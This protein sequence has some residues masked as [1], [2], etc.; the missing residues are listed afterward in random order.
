MSECPQTS[1]LLLLARMEGRAQRMLEAVRIVA[2]PENRL[3]LH[4][5]T[6]CDA[7]RVQWER[8]ATNR[9]L[10]LPTIAMVGERNSG[11]SYL[12]SR[13]VLHPDA[14]KW[15]APGLSE[16]TKTERLL[17]V[18]PES[19]PS[20]VDPW[21]S[22]WPLDREAMVDLG[23]PYMLLD[24]PGSGDRS[25]QLQA[26]AQAALSSA[27]IKVL[28]VDSARRSAEAYRDAMKPGDGSVILPAIHLSAGET[29][30]WAQRSQEEAEASAAEYRQWTATL[31]SYW[32]RATVLEPVILPEIDAMPD[33]EAAGELVRERLA[34]ALRE[35][36]LAH[37]DPGAL[38]AAELAAAWERFGRVAG[39][40]L[41]AILTPALRKRHAGLQEARRTLPTAV[42][43]HLF[44]DGAK[45]R[46]LVRHRLR[47]SLVESI[48]NGA[49]PFRTVAKLLCLT[50]GA[51]D[52]LVLG[53]GGSLPSLALAGAT[54]WR[55]VREKETA[56]ATL[57]A[58]LKGQIES[59]VQERLRGP[60]E[61]FQ[62]AV[63]RATGREH[64]T[65]SAVE[66]DLEGAQAVAHQWEEKLAE[67]A[68]LDRLSPRVIALFSF[69]GMAVFWFLLGGPL[70]H[71]YGQYVPATVASWSGE[72]VSFS[73]YPVLGFGFWSMALL[74]A[75][76]PLFGVALVTVGS[77]LSR[78]RV[79]RTEAALRAFWLQKADNGE[80]GLQI[81]LR[82]RTSEAV[83]TLFDEEPRE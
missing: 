49:F 64:A 72:W 59:V 63:D 47:L 12:A 69:L 28:V 34:D 61:D 2:G 5:K 37:S 71:L 23:T 25:Q 43:T 51:W 55:N 33:R 27:R 66:F 21:E 17:W 70:L 20:L 76:L 83:Q 13:L 58:A 41:G 30:R 78:R 73:R 38:A 62:A 1:P 39:E 42:M 81:R 65:V 19:P 50:T 57:G 31:A 15:F 8:I 11:K 35:A 16:A 10:T 6:T 67:Q 45:V 40:L 74:L 82:S 48:P 53:L 75:V 24:S 26:L 3:Y 9:G 29:V 80:L 44:G 54:V 14:Q 22:H 77:A 56:E 18:G 36:L 52:R 4:L 7:A 68:A 79:T 32:P 46:A 60:L